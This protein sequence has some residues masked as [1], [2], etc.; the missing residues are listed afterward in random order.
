M[1]MKITAVVALG[2]VFALGAALVSKS[3]SPTPYAG[4]SSA[5]PVN[6]PAKFAVISHGES[7]NLVDHADTAGGYT[8]FLF[9]ADW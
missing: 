8:V 9:G 3:K 6:D 5:Q 7:V 1:W 4:S 2:G